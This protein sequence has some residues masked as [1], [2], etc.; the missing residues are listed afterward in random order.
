MNPKQLKQEIREL[1]LSQDPHRDNGDEVVIRCPV[2][3]DSVKNYSSTHFHIKTDLNDDSMPLI[4][5]CFRCDASGVLNADIMRDIGIY[6]ITLNSSVKAYNK[7]ALKSLEKKGFTKYADKVNIN[8]PYPQNIDL[9]E[10][11]R[12]YISNRLGLDLSFDELVSLK[13]CFNF[14]DFLRINNINNITVSKAILTKLHHNYVGFISTN[15]DFIQ[16]R[17]IS[18]K[19]EKF[20]YYNYDVFKTIDRSRNFYSIPNKV[21]LMTTEDINIVLAEGVFDILGVFYHVYNNNLNNHIYSAVC[22]CGFASVVKYYLRK[23][24]TGKNIHLTIFSDIDKAPDFYSQLYEEVIG[25]IGSFTLCY[26][27]KSKDCGVPKDKIEI[28]TR[29]I[30]KPKKGRTSR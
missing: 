14:A 27:T 12:L 10:Q 22:G 17:D 20:R 9:A 15:N 2:C 21:D 25:W 28:I 1:L 18:G 6:D 26:N 30:P 13:V 8:L 24:L 19:E 29:K 7:Q 5:H 4:Y 23:G 16:F 11:K 3:G